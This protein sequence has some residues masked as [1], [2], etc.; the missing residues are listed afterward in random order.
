MYKGVPDGVQSFQDCHA[1]VPVAL[2]LKV[3]MLPGVG[4]TSV[5]T[6]V[7]VERQC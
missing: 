5:S 6:F 1:W 4:A 2:L 7:G 3:G